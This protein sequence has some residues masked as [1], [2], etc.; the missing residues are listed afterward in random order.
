MIELIIERS[1]T[2]LR[3]TRIS[4]NSKQRPSR[5]SYL[6]EIL[7]FLLYFNRR[8]KRIMP[9]GEVRR[10]YYLHKFMNST[11]DIIINFHRLILDYGFVRGMI[12]GTVRICHLQEYLEPE[13]GIIC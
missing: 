10:S 3:T 7:C 2:L 13:A 5:D 4:I 9:G 12:Y 6:D 1:I 8:F 11:A